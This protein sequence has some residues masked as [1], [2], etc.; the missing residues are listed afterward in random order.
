MSPTAATL[1]VDPEGGSV[2]VVVVVLEV[3]VL[4]EVVVELDV[5]VL[6]EVVVLEELDVV[7]LDEDAVVDE[8]V[9]PSVTI[10]WGAVAVVSR[11]SKY[12]PSSLE[13]LSPRVSTPPGTTAL[14][15][16]NS[17]HEFRGT[18]PS[19]TRFGP[20]LVGRFA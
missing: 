17:T 3:V 12:A 10:S 9:V 6:D 13:D 5:V 4:D 19:V 16:G 14:V 2:V 18:A 7:V 1:T 8:S 15:T 11:L 20:Q